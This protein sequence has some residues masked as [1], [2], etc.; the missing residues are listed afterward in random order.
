MK[1]KRVDWQTG[2]CEVHFENGEFSKFKKRAMQFCKTKTYNKNVG[3]SYLNGIIMS[4]V[5]NILK[6]GTDEI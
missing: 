4:N 2:D 5:K 6:G 3:N 1:L